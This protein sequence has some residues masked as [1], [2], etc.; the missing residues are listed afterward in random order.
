[1]EAI[2]DAMDCVWTVMHYTGTISEEWWSLL[3]QLLKS[4]VGGPDEIEGGFGYENFGVLQNYFRNIFKL[5]QREIFVRKIGD[6]NYFEITLNSILKVIEISKTSYA[7]S[8][9]A[10]VCKLLCAM[11]E[12][13]RGL[14]DEYLPHIIK[15]IV[16]EIS[17]E[18]LTQDY[19]NKLITTIYSSFYYNPLL[20]FK[21]L[22]EL[23]AVNST[24]EACYGNMDMFSDLEEI[25]WVIYG[26]CSI[27]LLSADEMHDSLKARMPNIM[28]HLVILIDKFTKA[29]IKQKER[30]QK[31]KD[32]GEFDDYYDMFGEGEDDEYDDIF[33]GEYVPSQC[34][35]DL[36]KGPFQQL[37]APLYFKQTL[38][39]ISES[40]KDVH[41]SLI[42]LISTDEQNTLESAFE[43]LEAIEN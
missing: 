34:N 21:I 43:K 11:L 29:F 25:W 40:N 28:K 42:P 20:T 16:D 30:K 14:I 38:Q 26:T 41:E 23:N 32:E 4:V 39:Q 18:E 36:Y 15:V 35:N 3:P 6:L 13:L 8:S 24:L 1:M 31:E 10:I 12:N 2:D 17:S 37:L 33:T 19:L 9:G 5:G 22:D 27:F 7:D